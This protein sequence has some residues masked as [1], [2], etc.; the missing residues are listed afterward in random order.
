MLYKL[1]LRHGYGGNNMK[2]NKELS[3]ELVKEI[4]NECLDCPFN[5]SFREEIVDYCL[6]ECPGGRR[7]KAIDNE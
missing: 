7:D 2:T 5:M 1:T 4:S 3:N 6:N